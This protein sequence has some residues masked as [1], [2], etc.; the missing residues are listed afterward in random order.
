MTTDTINPSIIVLPSPLPIVPKWTICP[1]GSHKLWRDYEEIL[2]RGE[3]CRS[4]LCHKKVVSQSQWHNEHYEEYRV[5]S[6]NIQSLKSTHRGF[7]PQV[8]RFFF[9]PFFFVLFSF[10][11]TCNVC[12]KPF[13]ATQSCYYSLKSSHRSSFIGLYPFFPLRQGGDICKELHPCQEQS[14]VHVDLYQILGHK[15]T[16]QQNWK[17]AKLERSAWGDRGR[18]LTR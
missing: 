10:S 5:V 16:V 9:P 7:E 18:T 2:H 13:C 11:S 3:I 6:Y 8:R 12:I 14:L 15:V 1:K 4:P 17:T